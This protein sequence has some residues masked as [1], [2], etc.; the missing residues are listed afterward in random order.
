GWT[1]QLLLFTGESLT[2]ANSNQIL[3]RFSI[4]EKHSFVAVESTKSS[5]FTL[6]NDYSKKRSST[7]LL[8][9]DPINF[10]I[11]NRW[12]CES[13]SF[14]IVRER[15]V[16]YSDGFLFQGETDGS[17]TK[18]AEAPSGFQ[19]A[20]ASTTE[21]RVIAEI[22]GGILLWNTDNWEP[23]AQNSMPGHDSLFAVTDEGSLRILTENTY[24]DS[25]PGGKFGPFVP[26]PQSMTRYDS[27][28]SLSAD[29]ESLAFIDDDLRVQHIRLGGQKQTPKQ[30]Q[31]PNNGRP[32]KV[33]ISSSGQRVAVV[34]HP[35]IRVDDPDGTEKASERAFRSGLSGGLFSQMFGASKLTESCAIFELPEVTAHAQGF[36][37]K[38]AVST[39]PASSLYL[40]SDRDLLCWV[41]IRELGRW[42]FSKKNA[43]PKT[44]RTSS[45]DNWGF[46][47]FNDLGDILYQR[48][49]PAD[50]FR[51][52]A[53]WDSA[54]NRKPQ[55]IAESV[56]DS[57]IDQRL[58]YALSRDSTRLIIA[59]SRDDESTVSI[60]GLPGREKLGEFKFP[61]RVLNMRLSPTDR[62][63]GVKL[64]DSRYAVIPND[65]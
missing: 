54:H 30:L 65:L 2:V 52:Q 47:A 51:G 53:I 62:F 39:T 64:S 42:E 20:T 59:E 12:Q 18:L 46:Y 63:I 43:R 37:S 49:A 22:E 15:P 14:A 25:I 29:G 16:F 38:P 50:E 4:E 27:D 19:E 28:R 10:A 7:V 31:V 61:A 21:R 48:D 6:C 13:D 26:L 55:V 57:Q 9:R 40:S 3:G 56:D 33:V 41:G 36:I 44:R 34:F 17:Q 5:I 45:E 60:L 32:S 58:V 11:S 35:E 1:N 23:H 8:E 24:C